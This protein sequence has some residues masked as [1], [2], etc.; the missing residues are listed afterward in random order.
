MKIV[1]LSYSSLLYSLGL[2]FKYK[3]IDGCNIKIVVYN[4]TNIIKFLNYM[5]IK[6]IDII[7]YDYQLV[8]TRN[9]YEILMN[10][11]FMKKFYKKN[12]YNIKNEIIYI[13]NKNECLEVFDLYYRIRN[14]NEIRYVNFDPEINSK[15]SISFKSL[16]YKLYNKL[17]ITT[18]Y[19]IKFLGGYLSIIKN[20]VI[21][22][23]EY[24]KE[25]VELIKC[26][27]PENS[28]IILETDL[29]KCNYCRKLDYV[30]NSTNIYNQISMVMSNQIYIKPHPI[31][32]NIYYEIYGKD[33][34]IENFIPIEFMINDGNIDTV[35]GVMSIALIYAIKN[36]VKNVISTIKLYD[37][38]DDKEKDKIVS[39]L[40]KETDNRIMMP[41]SINELNKIINNIAEGAEKS[42]EI[43]N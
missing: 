12:I 27:F 24:K 41:N 14:K 6:E 43:I 33:K 15:K 18:P 34:I 20:S 23:I 5:G 29:S 39:W 31:F 22:K 10:F 9:P 7:Y 26:N 38:M 1:I 30:L 16:I 21:K 32:N 28:I 25:K 2:Y 4:N 40:I 17:Y 37:F 42:D 8:Y 19:D 3:D 35:I 36:E 11:L 13:F